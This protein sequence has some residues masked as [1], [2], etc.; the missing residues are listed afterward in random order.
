L[1]E[2]LFVKEKLGTKIK[3]SQNQI[4]NKEC[5]F[6][7]IIFFIDIFDISKILSFNRLLK[8]VLGGLGGLYKRIYIDRGQLS[9][10]ESTL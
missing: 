1:L 5:Y 8:L 7:D 2:T 3:Y 4:R 6:Y 9:I 10:K